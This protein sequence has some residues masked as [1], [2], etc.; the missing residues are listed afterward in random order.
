M[1]SIIVPPAPKVITGPKASSVVKPHADLAAAAETRHRLHGDAIDARIGLGTLDGPASPGGGRAPG[2]RSCTS[3][4]T[5]CTSL[6]CVMSGESIFSAT[7]KPSW[8][9][10]SMASLA[11]RDSMVRVTGM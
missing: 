1:S 11:L 10:I 6:L 8:L 3:S 9:A 7:G 5:P 2:R 4:A